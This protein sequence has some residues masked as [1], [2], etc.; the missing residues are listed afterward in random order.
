MPPLRS[1][2]PRGRD[3]SRRRRRGSLA[4]S[5]RARVARHRRGVFF[6]RNP[7]VARTSPLERGGASVPRR[8]AT[9]RVATRG[10]ARGGGGSV[11]PPAL[12]R[13]RAASR[14]AV[15]SVDADVSGWI[16]SNLDDGCFFAS[17]IRPPVRP[18]TVH[19]PA[20]IPFVHRRHRQRRHRRHRRRGRGQEPD[21]GDRHREREVAESRGH[22]PAS[23]EEGGGALRGATGPHRHRALEA[24]R[25]AQV[26]SSGEGGGEVCRVSDARRG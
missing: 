5:S 23:G 21:R 6:S 9:R 11:K 15:A 8:D 10:G 26:A 12:R 1:R 3:A 22:L 18:L 17:P 2:R 16:E 14:V 19:H 7:S 13:V 20:P 25:R 4:A 24:L